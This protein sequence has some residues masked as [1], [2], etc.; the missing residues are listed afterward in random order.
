MV[1]DETLC[2]PHVQMNPKTSTGFM[3]SSPTKKS[4]WLQNLCMKN[5]CTVLFFFQIVNLATGTIVQ[6][7]GINTIYFEPIFHCFSCCCFVIKDSMLLNSLF[8]YFN[9]LSFL[10]CPFLQTCQSDLNFSLEP[11]IFASSCV[12][13]SRMLWKFIISYKLCGF[14]P[15]VQR[16]QAWVGHYDNCCLVHSRTSHSSVQLHSLTQLPSW[17]FLLGQRNKFNVCGICKDLC[18]Q[19]KLAYSSWYQ[20]KK[21]HSVL[22]VFFNLAV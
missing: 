21:Y 9:F 14:S 5:V 20:W 3:I 13:F 12:F 8:H 2:D 7:L 22:S 15:G 18:K 1:F 4:Y 11:F 10:V 17:I 19:F 6:A 16:D